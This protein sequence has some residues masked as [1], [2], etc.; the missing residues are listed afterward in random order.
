MAL[1]FLRQISSDKERTPNKYTIEMGKIIK[2]A[3]EDAGLSQKELAERVYK[4]QT[5]LSD[6][7]R[8][9]AEVSSGTLALLAD[10]L[11]KPLSFFYPWFMY[12]EFE[13]EKIDPLEQELLLQFQKILSGN[14]QKLAIG[15][16]KVIATFDPEDMVIELLPYIQMQQERREAIR[17]P[18]P[19]LLR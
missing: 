6:M 19:D 1:D 11:E 13:P 15:M 9:K 17:R 4:K 16:V 10:V 7:E 2:Q 5:S 8:G 18:F 14:L 12:K 3:R